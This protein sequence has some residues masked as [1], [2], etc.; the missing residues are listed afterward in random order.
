VN[1]LRRELASLLATGKEE[2]ARIKVEGVLREMNLQV[3]LEVCQ[4][5]CELLT[6]RQRQLEADKCVRSPTLPTLPPLHLQTPLH[7]DADCSVGPRQLNLQ[8][9]PRG[10]TVIG[11][12]KFSPTRTP[13][14]SGPVL[15]HTRMCLIGAG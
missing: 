1:G 4:L 13:Q 7:L 11:A 10:W 2:S 14:R 3:V 6:V 9:P 8:R 15:E 12:A 5:F